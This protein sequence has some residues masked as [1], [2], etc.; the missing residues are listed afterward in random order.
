MQPRPIR[1]EPQFL[2]RIWGSR[3]LAPIYPHK[4]NLREPIG[5]AW[6]TGPQSNVA[7]GPLTGTIDE[8][9]QN[10]P[11]E[12]RGSSFS[13]QQASSSKFPILV[14]FLFPADQLSIQVHPDDAFAAKNENPGE[15]GKTEMW[16]AVYAEPDAALLLGLLPGI[17]RQR[18]GSSAKDG[19]L[20]N[21]L[22]HL[23]VSPGDT[24]FVAPGTPHTI[25]PGMILCEV[26]QNSDL[27]Y[28]L[29]DYDRRDAQGHPRQ[30]HIEKAMAV[31]DFQNRRGGRVS[32]LPFYSSH[33]THKS[34]LAACRYFAAER[35]D[36][37]SACQAQ[38]DP[39]RFELLTF[40]CGKGALE[41]QGGTVAFQQGECWLIPA[42]L[43]R[44]CLRPDG[45]A[46]LLRSYV[47]SLEQ[48]RDGL[49]ATGVSGPA[50]DK[51][52]FH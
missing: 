33:E 19:G 8:V 48:L 2:P 41:H 13:H 49:L 3:S 22:Q 9:W 27:T 28:R 14:K 15:S 37:G 16:H 36:L 5:E 7:E 32:A 26:Q 10:M 17:E 18:F 44:F 1:I 6:L 51:V 52:V 39:Q 38:S 46:A 34:V 50:I 47:P 25:G 4:S 35:W 11:A 21:F 42:N 45:E 31:I 23:K 20:E 12:W 30:L 24:F 29:Y 43:G 40:L